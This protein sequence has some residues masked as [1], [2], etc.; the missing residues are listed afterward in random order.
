MFNVSCLI[1]LNTVCI[2]LFIDLND[3]TLQGLTR[4]AL[5]KVVGT[6]GNHVLYALSPANRACELSNQVSLDL[7]GIGVRLSI[8]VLVNGALRSLGKRGT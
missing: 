3:H 8:Y 6:I 5:C 2:D 7:S 4:T 1:L